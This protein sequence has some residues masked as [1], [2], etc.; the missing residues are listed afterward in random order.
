MDI[1]WA[2]SIPK[3][4]SV[5]KHNV[6]FEPFACI[7]KTGCGAS[8]RNQLH[9]KT[10]VMFPE[11]QRLTV[12]IIRFLVH[13]FLYTITIFQT[14]LFWQTPSLCLQHSIWEILWDFNVCREGKEFTVCNF[15]KY[16]VF[17]EPGKM[18]SDHGW[19]LCFNIPR[20]ATVSTKQNRLRGGGGAL[21]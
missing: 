14:T 19:P 17:P 5:N 16:L 11:K 1:Y 7:F 4:Y 3:H 13:W 15:G 6:V 21:L 8:L 9:W 10:Q 20:G 2:F 18:E 12:H